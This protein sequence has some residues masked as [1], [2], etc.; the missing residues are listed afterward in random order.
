MKDEI[1]RVR[2]DSETGQ[3]LDI[4]LSEKGLRFR[5]KRCATY[6]CKLGGPFLTK[7][8]MAQ[9]E[10][11][12][13]K[14]CEFVEDS[15][16]KYGELLMTSAMKNKEDG[17]CVFLRLDEK[18]KAYECS[19]YEIRPVLCRLFPFEIKIVGV[20]SFLLKILPCN[21]LNDANGELVNKRFIIKHL[22]EKNHEHLLKLTELVQL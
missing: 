6:C 4:N 2:I 19:I 17:S 5:C 12:G 14:A 13:Y 15:K 20:G 8:D 3:F 9:I 7:E 21:G 11:V 16:G 1:A 10:S 18:R 22:L